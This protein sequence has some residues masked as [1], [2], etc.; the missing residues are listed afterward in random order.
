MNYDPLFVINPKLPCRACA[1]TMVKL[2]GECAHCSVSK[3]NV[4]CKTCKTTYD[5]SRK[6]C[7][8]CH[9]SGC[10]PVELGNLWAP[11]PGFLVCGGPSINK[12]PFNKLRERGIVSLAVNNAAGHVPVTSFVYSDPQSKFHHGVHLDPKMLTFAPIG[13]LKRHVRAKL[14]DGTFRRVRMKVRNC[15]GTLAFSRKTQFDA[16]TFLTTEYAHWGRGGK[17]TVDD[18]PFRCLCTMLLGIRLLHYLGCPRVYMLGVDFKRTEDAQYAFAQSAGVRNGRY[19]KENAMLAELKPIFDKDGF[20][21]FNCNPESGC[22][23]FPKVSFEEAF[24]DCKGA[25][26]DEPFDMADWYSKSLAKEQE[27]KYPKSISYDKLAA[28]QRGARKDT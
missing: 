25:V 14:P 9:G 5:E 22:D 26:P 1:A 17:Q 10:H 27:E 19:S 13:K 6:V 15:P 21:L 7:P 18:C 8:V 16:K 23:V 24:A 20:K 2:N 11:S 4:P 3:I 12:I 28:I